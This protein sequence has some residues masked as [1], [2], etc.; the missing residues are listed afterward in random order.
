MQEKSERNK[1]MVG[2]VD[3]FR[4]K[5]YDLAVLDA[6]SPAEYFYERRGC[7]TIKQETLLIGEMVL[8]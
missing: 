1:S 5:N 2:R 7:R 8:L 6:S 3:Y 4:R